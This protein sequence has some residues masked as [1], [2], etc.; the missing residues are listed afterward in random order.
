MAWSGG[1]GRVFGALVVMCA[2]AVS[3]GYLYVLAL[4]ADD[5][6]SGAVAKRYCRLVTSC[7]ILSA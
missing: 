6:V 1:P 7:C 4:G 5:P 2:G 3:G